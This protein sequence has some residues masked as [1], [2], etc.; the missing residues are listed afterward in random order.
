MQWLCRHI[1]NNGNTPTAF[2][3]RVKQ[4]TKMNEGERSAH[5]LEVLLNAVELAG[6]VDQLNLA[7]L[8]CMELIGRRIQLILDAHA[9]PGVAVWEGAEHFLGLGKRA[10]G[11]APSLQAHVAARLKDEAEVDKQRDKARDVRKLRLKGGTNDK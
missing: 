4:E 10:K 3:T 1:K 2:L 9:T 8:S 6:S 5:E 11:I 7:N